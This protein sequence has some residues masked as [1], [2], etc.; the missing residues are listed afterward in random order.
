MN[1][2][3]KNL[4]DTYG[5]STLRE[6]D[7][8]NEDEITAQFSDLHLDAS[9]TLKIQNLFFDYYYRWSIDAFTLGLHLGLSLQ[10]HEP[11]R[12]PKKAPGPS[13]PVPAYTGTGAPDSPRT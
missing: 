3:Y 13:G 9:A 5:D 4:F 12:S 7:N 10:D 2:A 8:Y 6:Y 11:L 1:P